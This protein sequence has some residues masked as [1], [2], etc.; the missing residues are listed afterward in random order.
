MIGTLLIAAGIL[1]T[2]SLFAKY[3]DLI[4]DWA[5]LIVATYKGIK[6][7]LVLAKKVKDVVAK[8]YTRLTNGK[9]I[10]TESEEEIDIEDVP[11]EIKQELILNKE[12]PIKEYVEK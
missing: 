6:Y 3:V 4:V 11:Q 8:L 12:I 9:I 5:D 10:V 7:I 2:I 1:A